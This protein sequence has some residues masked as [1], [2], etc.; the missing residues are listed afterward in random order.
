MQPDKTSPGTK[1]PEQ[2]LPNTLK[3]GLLQWKKDGGAFV[4]SP[5]PIS[6][7]D[8]PTQMFQFSG[9]LTLKHSVSAGELTDY[10]SDTPATMNH[11]LA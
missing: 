8:N 11:F 7:S 6:S 1:C 10:S 5:P 9:M 2:K 4:L 3:K